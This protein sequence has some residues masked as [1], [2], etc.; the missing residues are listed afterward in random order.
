M[1]L[2]IVAV[3]AV[4]VA[5][6]WQVFGR[7]PIPVTAPHGS[8][9][10]VA[11]RRDLYGDAVNEALFMRPGQYLTRFLVYVDNR[12]VDGAVVGTAAAVGGLSARLRRW[13]TGFVRSYALSMLAGAAIVVVAMLLVRL[14]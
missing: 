7:R 2:I 1:T 4:G 12:G 9:V 6:A 13:Q 5:L 11:A 3:V 14:P 8:L 10:T